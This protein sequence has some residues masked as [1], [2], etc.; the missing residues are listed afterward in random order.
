M[1]SLE[2]PIK[3]AIASSG[4][5]GYRGPNYDLIPTR[6]PLSLVKKEEGGVQ[7]LRSIANG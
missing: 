4:K 6:R 3:R 2:G 1:G 7:D 5:G